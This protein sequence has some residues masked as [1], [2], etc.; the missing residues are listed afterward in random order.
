[1]A[2][3]ASLF[4]SKG[5]Q[6]LAALGA[7]MSG[8]ISL[9]ITAYF[10]DGE[11]LSMLNGSSKYLAPRESVYSLVINPRI[12]NEERFDVL[13]ELQRE[14]ARLDEAYSRY[15]S[16]FRRGRLSSQRLVRSDPPPLWKRRALCSLGTQRKMTFWNSTNVWGLGRIR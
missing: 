3:T 14:Y 1:M 16:L 13:T 4:G 11:V 10:S 9:F 6:L 12:S 15:F 8:T 5:V 2:V 7:G